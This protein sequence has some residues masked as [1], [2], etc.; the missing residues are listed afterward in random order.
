MTNGMIYGVLCSPSTWDT[1]SDM[2]WSGP[3][4]WLVLTASATLCLHLLWFWRSGDAAVLQRLGSAWIALG[5]GSIVWCGRSNIRTAIERH[6]P[7]Q[8]GV[9]SQSTAK[10]AAQREAREKAMPGATATA[11]TEL[12]WSAWLVLAGTI[13]NGYGDLPFR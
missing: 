5:L 2:R 11:W 3:P 7:R 6:L 12:V 1:S 9:F 4:W 8:N 13:V 10:T